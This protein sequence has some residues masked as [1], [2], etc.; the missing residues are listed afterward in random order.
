MIAYTYGIPNFQE[1]NIAEL[2]S[3]KRKMQHIK[4][5]L[6]SKDYIEFANDGIW[7]SGG[8]S[9]FKHGLHV[10]MYK[11]LSKQNNT[12]GL[13]LG[14]ALDLL[15]GGTHSP[16]E[17][18]NIKSKSYL[19]DM[20]TRLKQKGDVKTYLTY[21][22]NLLYVVFGQYIPNKYILFSGSE[23]YSYTSTS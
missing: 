20:Y 8:S 21:N 19:L 16:E 3:A 5:E 4:I 9:I 2:L 1:A 23:L 17:L 7:V 14:S 13:L 22:I 6:L 15:A 11:K 18:Y 10:H 12:K